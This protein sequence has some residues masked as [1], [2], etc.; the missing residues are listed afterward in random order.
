MKIRKYDYIMD[1]LVIFSVAVG[2][3]WS[4]GRLCG[5]GYLGK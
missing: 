5:V 2:V 3:G 4:G 1:T